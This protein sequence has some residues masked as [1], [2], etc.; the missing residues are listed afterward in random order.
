MDSLRYSPDALPET[1]ACPYVSLCSSMQTGMTPGMS[2]GETGGS[3]RE[4]L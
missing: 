1:W 2:E 3:D 4:V